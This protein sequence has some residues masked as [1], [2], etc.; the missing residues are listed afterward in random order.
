MNMVTIL[1][2]LLLMAAELTR[3]VVIDSSLPAISDPR[4]EPSEQLDLSLVLTSHG[5]S[6]KGA[7]ESLVPERDGPT[8]PCL[9]G[10]CLDLASYDLGALN[11][12]LGSIKDAH[13][14][15]DTVVLV[16]DGDVPYEVIVG[17]MDAARA[18]A[19]GEGGRELFPRV[20]V[21]GGV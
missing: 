17:V 14:D 1:I 13:P 10:R 21:A 5:I 8:V 16:P 7:P 12:L 18:D 2:P 19:M 20:V 6:V 11:K 9:R 3:V 4:P 15:S